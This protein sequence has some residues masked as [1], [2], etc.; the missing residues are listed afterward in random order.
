MVAVV[1]SQLD[2]AAG[3]RFDALGL[4]LALGAALSQTVYVVISRDGYPDG[5]HGA[6]DDR[7]ARRDRR[8]RRPSL[9]LIVAG[10]GRARLPA[11]R[12]RRSCR[13]CC[14]PG[15]S[16]RPSRRSGSSTGIR[17]DRRDARRDPDA[18]RAGRRRRARGAG[19][20]ARRLAPIQL[21]RR[22]RDPRRRAHPPA[23]AAGEPD[24]SRPTT[25]GRRAGRRRPA[26]PG[27]PR[28]VRRPDPVLIVDDHA[29][30]RRGM[31][32]F[33]D[34]HDD[35]EVV[36]EAADGAGGA[37][38]DRATLAPDV[39]V[40][41]LLMPGIDGIA[42]TAEIKARH[43]AVEVVALTSFVEEDRVTAAHR[44]R[45]QRVPAQGRRGRRPRRRH[46]RGRTQA[47][48][49]S[50]RRSPGSSRAVR[51]RAAGR[52]RPRSAGRQ[53]ARRRR[54][55]RASRRPPARARGPR[56]RRARAVEPGHRRRARDHRAHG[57]DP[58][59]EHPGQARAHQPDAGG[60]VRGRARRRAGDGTRGAR[61][62][63]TRGRRGSG[64]G[65]DV[66]G[67]RGAGHRVRPRH[68]ADRRDVG[69]PA[70]RPVRRVPDDRARPARPRRARRPSRS[71]SMARPTALGDDD[72]R[73]GRRWPGDRRR[74][75]ARRLRRRWTSRPVR[76]SA[77]AASSCPAPPPSPSGS[78]RCPY[79]ALAAVDGPVDG[80]RL[81]RAEPRGSSG[82]ASRRRSPTRSSPA[83]SGRAA[84][85]RA[86]G[87]SSARGSCRG[88]PP[89]RAR[90]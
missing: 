57:A 1:A 65:Y 64:D 12:R 2:P 71:R 43:P 4:G 28:R 89:T 56:R 82:A 46:P 30:V 84:A 37:R 54:D 79:L 34:L 63:L 88:S 5:P 60:P 67:R 80:A 39:V 73:R 83:G 26:V 78:G 24:R 50:T 81:D 23:T 61:P 27:G 14:S 75:V 44:G 33:L 55:A 25:R 76:P 45:R 62:A 9:A 3:I 72:R 8:R 59:L 32:D 13:C 77:S 48:S 85:Q 7:R 68:A 19:C 21:A 40:M 41:D 29:M 49:T 87:R 86:A 70:G 53:T 22:G 35:L 18:L 90:R 69:R 17:V 36:G 38:A 10:A 6:G 52:R 42:A 11:P 16:R 31:R 74:A 47:R 66:A 51:D 58:R 15:S 20:S